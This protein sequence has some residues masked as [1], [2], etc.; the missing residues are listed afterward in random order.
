M[1]KRIDWKTAPIGKFWWLVGYIQAHHEE[2]RVGQTMFNVLY[3]VRPDL[4]EQ[5]RTTPLDPF[6]MDD[7]STPEFQSVCDWIE[8]NW[9]S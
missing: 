2:W 5:I 8:R 1:V 9:K 7:A 3:E 4:S 6:Y